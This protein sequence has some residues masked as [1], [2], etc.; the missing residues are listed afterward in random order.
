MDN[1]DFSILDFNTLLKS[2]KSICESDSKTN[3]IDLLKKIKFESDDLKFEEY[4]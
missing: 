2:Y 4:C 3:L 1:N